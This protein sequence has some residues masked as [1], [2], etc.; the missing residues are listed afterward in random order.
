MLPP[1]FNVSILLWP[2][3]VGNAAAA[4]VHYS[5]VA[6]RSISNFLRVSPLRARGFIMHGSILYVAAACQTNTGSW[7]HYWMLTSCLDSSPIAA[8]SIADCRRVC[9]CS[10]CVV[11]SDGVSARNMRRISVACEAKHSNVFS[12]AELWWIRASARWMYIS[13]T[14]K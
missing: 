11:C 12:N 6:F 8:F 2:R 10:C 4:I 13:I 7:I 14:Q 3:N 9:V 5:G 1:M